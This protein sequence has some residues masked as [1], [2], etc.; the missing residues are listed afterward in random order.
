MSSAYRCFSICSDL[1]CA[2]ES[3][4]LS[5]FFNSAFA[6]GQRTVHDNDDDDGPGLT[7]GGDD[8][9]SSGQ[10]TAANSCADGDDECSAWRFT[11]GNG[12][13]DVGGSG[14]ETSAWRFTAGSGGAGGAR[15]LFPVCI[16][17]FSLGCS[18]SES[19]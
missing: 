16:A 7:M 4:C 18:S 19:V 15:V 11:T 12:G 5:I 9:G 1:P 6:L 10:F 2:R 14:D 17:F 8:K 3:R 13:A